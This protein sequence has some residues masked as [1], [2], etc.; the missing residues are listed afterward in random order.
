MTT[1][2]VSWNIAKRHKA[3]RQLV[4]MGADVALLQEAGMPPADVADRVDTGPRE[5]WDSH[6][7]NSDWWEGRGWHGLFDRWAKV[8][9]LSDRVEVEWFKQVSPI[10]AIAAD[11][12]GVSG[13]GAIAAARVKPDDA[14]PFIIVSMYA[15]WM[16]PH[17]SVP[18]PWWAGYSDA[19]A[20]RIISDLSVFIG[21]TD[22]S[23][24][25]IL[26]AGDLNIIYGALGK[27]PQWLT[28]R[29]Q[30]VFD[31]MDALGM[32]FLGPQHPNGRQGEPQAN[33]LAA[34]HRERS[35]LLRLTPIQGDGL[36]STRLRVCL[37]RL[38]RERQGVRHELR[39]GLGGQRP[40]PPADR[41]LRLIPRH[42]CRS[43]DPLF[44]CV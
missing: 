13:I 31:R 38:P 2:V 8:V 32:E 10:M 34:R 41:G 3:W 29:D 14:E 28:A 15:R 5:H 16:K 36:D 40:L 44:A 25:R 18:T 12:I 37:A 43:S 22:P 39:R 11:E 6:V 9:K 33:G 7:W 23:T 27:D 1:T 4:E 30:S 20:H 19:S 21:N 42:C 24:H 17:P 35:D 26:A